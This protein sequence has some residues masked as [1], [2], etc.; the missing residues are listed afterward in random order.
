MRWFIY[1]SP[2]RFGDMAL[3]TMS[4]EPTEFIIQQKAVR[5]GPIIVISEE[6]L[7]NERQKNK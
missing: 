1:R 5:Y 2:R 7:S 4:F 6:E 3:E